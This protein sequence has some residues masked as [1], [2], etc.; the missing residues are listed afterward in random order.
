MTQDKN[1]LFDNKLMKIYQTSLEYLSKTGFDFKEKPS[2]E[3]KLRMKTSKYDNIFDGLAEGAHDLPVP[4]KAG[5]NVLS[6]TFMEVYGLKEEIDL[7]RYLRVVLIIL[8]QFNGPEDEDML[9]Y[10]I[11]TMKLY[12]TVGN[13]GYQED[14]VIKALHIYEQFL[15]KRTQCHTMLSKRDYISFARILN[16]RF[17]LYAKSEKKALT[18]IFLKD[19]HRKLLTYL[20]KDQTRTMLFNRLK[21]YNIVEIKSEEELQQLANSTPT[22]VEIIKKIN[23]W[24]NKQLT[25]K[26]NYYRL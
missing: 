1:G 24:V 15:G 19:I 16:E 25:D 20:A 17:V 10:H 22:R 2:S 14:A 7:S 11:S 12:F 23:D 5:E 13:L 21:Y 18:I 3:L 9:K 6:K 8:R 26:K 4:Y